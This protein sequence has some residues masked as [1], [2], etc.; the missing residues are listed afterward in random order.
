MDK[1]LLILQAVQL[2]RP[3]TQLEVEAELMTPRK[4]GRP[5]SSSSRAG[6]SNPRGL[7]ALRS[8]VEAHI[9]DIKGELEDVKKSIKELLLEFRKQRLQSTAP[10]SSELGNTGLEGAHPEAK[11]PDVS[12]EIM[13]PVWGRNAIGTI[14][15]V[16]VTPHEVAEGAAEV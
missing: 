12:M 2:D 8:E 4:S 15:E 13:D 3:P 14:T 6:G 9:Q 16:H 1:Q 7:Q 5:Q 11:L 10:S